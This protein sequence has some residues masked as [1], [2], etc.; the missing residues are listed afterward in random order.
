[1]SEL[2]G[3]VRA[4]VSET[5]RRDLANVALDDD[6][7]EQLALDSL[8]ALHILAALEKR[9]GVRFPDD[10]LGEM[11]TLR[12]LIEAVERLRTSQPQ[13][14][15]PGPRRDGTEAKE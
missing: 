7:V 1:M 6:L 9:L 12:G 11:R 13:G 3:R 14:S 8:G 4:I 10:R 15:S 5:S 2:E